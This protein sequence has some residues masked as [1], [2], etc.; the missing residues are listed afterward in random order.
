[1]LPTAWQMTNAIVAWQV[2]LAG[3]I[4]AVV[5]GVAHLIGRL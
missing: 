2:A 4:A 1:M 5:F 3:L